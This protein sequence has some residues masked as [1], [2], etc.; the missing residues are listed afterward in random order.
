MVEERKFKRPLK[1]F[2]RHPDQSLGD[3]LSW[4]YLEDLKVYAIKREF[5]VPYFKFVKDL[6]TL[7]WW[8]VE[9]LVKTKNIQQCLWGPEVRH[10]EQKLWYYIRAQ[11]YAKFPEWK[12]HY[13]KRTIKIDPVTGFL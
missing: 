5:G 10:H 11:A 13:P 8:D 7:S 6:K 12:P 4:G 9:E 2:T 3:I 1:F